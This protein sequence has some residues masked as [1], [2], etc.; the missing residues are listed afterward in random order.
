[1]GGIDEA[2]AAAEAA[3]ALMDCFESCIEGFSALHGADVAL[4]VGVHFG[5]VWERS[6]P[7]KRLYSRSI[8]LEKDAFREW[9]IAALKY[10]NG[11]YV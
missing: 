11:F 9:G 4:R 5:P 3:F 6:D 1:M 2:M 10:S 8:A 7:L